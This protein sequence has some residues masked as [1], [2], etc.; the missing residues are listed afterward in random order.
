MTGNNEGKGTEQKKKGK[1]ARLVTFQHQV[2]FSHCYNCLWRTASRAFRMGVSHCP[3]TQHTEAHSKTDNYSTA[4][5]RNKPQPPWLPPSH[6][7][8]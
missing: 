5:T 3:P 1:T 8:G 6:S 7:D 4:D 2:E